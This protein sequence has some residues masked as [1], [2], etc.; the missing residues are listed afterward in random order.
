MYA[1]FLSCKFSMK[2]LITST[3]ENPHNFF[4]FKKNFFMFQ[5]EFREKFVL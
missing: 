4:H 3:W 5:R 2:E 1:N